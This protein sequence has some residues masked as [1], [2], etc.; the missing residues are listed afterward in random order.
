MVNANP[1]GRKKYNN[2][3]IQY[4]N[5]G[6]DNN[7]KDCRIDMYY[8]SEVGL[9][10]MT[11]DFV[12]NR[13]IDID[14]SVESTSDSTN[15]IIYDAAYENNN[16][17]DKRF[18]ALK[19]VLLYSGAIVTLLLDKQ[20]NTLLLTKVIDTLN[21]DLV[22]NKH[23]EFSFI[24]LG[25]VNPNANSL[26]S[27]SLSN[28][29]EMSKIV[30]DSSQ[31]TSD[32]QSKI[33]LVNLKLFKPIT[34]RIALFTDVDLNSTYRA[35]IEFGLLVCLSIPQSVLKLDNCDFNLMH[36]FDYEEMQEGLIPSTNIDK[37]DTYYIPIS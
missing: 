17:G 29:N 6:D 24:P 19:K 1:Y 8:S 25:K 32:I 21:P 31:S 10:S 22:K 3:I 11:D 9:L 28:K 30:L 23:L 15:T 16:N 37:V 20:E 12:S 36:I 35:R 18:I 5:S 14:S 34:S 27:V 7:A 26:T 33:K 2:T 13:G 4:K